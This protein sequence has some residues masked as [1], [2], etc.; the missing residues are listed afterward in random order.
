M[1]KLNITKKGFTIGQR[2]N[3]SVLI[4]TECDKTD[5]TNDDI[6]NTHD[7]NVHRRD[8]N[9]RSVRK[10]TISLRSKLI[11]ET[12]MAVFDLQNFHINVVKYFD[13]SDV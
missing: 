2:G 10:G 8:G 9:I 13:L 3:V 6:H 12:N 1:P 7:V 5:L 4:K 11:H